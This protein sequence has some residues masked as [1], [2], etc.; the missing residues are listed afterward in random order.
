MNERPSITFPQALA[1]YQT[2][3]SA[4][5][6]LRFFVRTFLPFFLSCTAPWAHSIDG[7]SDFGVDVRLGTKQASSTLPYF[8]VGPSPPVRTTGANPRAQQ[9]GRFAH[10]GLY[11]LSRRGK[12]EHLSTFCSFCQVR[13]SRQAHRIP[14][15]PLFF[16][17]SHHRPYGSITS[18]IILPPFLALLR[19]SPRP[20]LPSL[21]LPRPARPRA[22]G[23]RLGDPSFPLL[24]LFLF[25]SPLASSP[26][27]SRSGRLVLRLT[28]EQPRVSTSEGCKRRQR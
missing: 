22:S 9:D 13:P 14:I 1:S 11:K 8:G 20:L 18:V 17:L 24:P 5:L 6:L 21:L 10:R 26:T 25:S 15:V 23:P 19:P 27:L 4:L 28:P 16:A 3:L 12:H 2:F 7:Q